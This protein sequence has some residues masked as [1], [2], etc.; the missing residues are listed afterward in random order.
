MKFKRYDKVIISNKNLA[1]PEFLGRTG[2]FLEYIE[3][4]PTLCL[5]VFDC[6]KRATAQYVDVNLLS[7]LEVI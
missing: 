3:L 6:H 4:D 7:L 5:M 1:N 2:V